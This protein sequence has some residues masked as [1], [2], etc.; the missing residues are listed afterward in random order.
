MALQFTRNAKVYVQLLT[1]PQADGGTQVAIW[2]LGVL[3]GFSFSQTSNTT[4][5]TVSE[6]GS[7]S[8][9][10]SLTFN[11]SL[12]PVEWSFSTY[13]RPVLD[14]TPSPD[15]VRC[16]EEPLWAMLMGGDSYAAG[17]FTGD[18][19][20]SPDEVN[21]VSNTSNA[22]GFSQSNVSSMSD[23]WQIW[24]AFED[25]GNTQYY[26]LPKSVANTATIDFDIEGITTIQWSGNA[27][28]VVE[29]NALPSLVGVLNGAYLTDTSNFIRNRLS[30]VSLLRTDVSPDISY[31]IVLTG[32]SFTVENNISYLTP[33]ELGKVNIPLAN[34]TGTRKVSGN[35]TC[36]LD[37]AAGR[38][39][40]LLA[41]LAADVTTVRN[42]FAL[43]INVGGDTGRRIALAMPTAMIQVP[44]IGVED[45]ITLDV[46]FA[47]QVAGGDIDATNEA[48]ITY[49]VP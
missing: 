41:D 6:A 31:D 20:F 8:R 33:E 46:G 21:A 1:A 40:E 43:N 26:R 47:G 7:T 28:Q 4:E 11:D 15:Q 16:P 14:T 18:G 29:E 17:V 24:F 37:N 19:T 30:T 23:K 2:Q 10:A 38:S 39:S 22:F 5:V 32:G 27:S 36:Y 42:V 48:T 12:A 9:R 3:T 44:S 35:M 34:I 13:A 25:A 45:L 49:Y